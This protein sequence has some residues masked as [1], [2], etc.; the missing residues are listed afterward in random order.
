MPIFDALM[1]GRA[2][3]NTRDAIRDLNAL[4]HEETER[5]SL[6]PARAMLWKA[7]CDGASFLMLQLFVDNEDKAVD[8]RLRRHRR[9]LNPQRLAA[10]YWWM[11]LYQLVLFK[12]R[13]AEGYEVE[14]EF[15]ELLGTAQRFLN[16]LA[17]IDGYGAVHPG[18]WDEGWASQAS[19]EAAL[20][21][22]NTIMRMLG[23]RIDLKQRINRV[24]LFTSASERAYDSTVKAEASRR[25]GTSI[26]GL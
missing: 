10:V 21:L 26:P 23:L 17:S 20:G 1:P 2:R 24:S 4:A 11:V 5:Q 22:Y 9:K 25:N 8:W 14:D 7:I 15:S 3:S 18:Q 16:N 13:G 19:L 12:N 6:P